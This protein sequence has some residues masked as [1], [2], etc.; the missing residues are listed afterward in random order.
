MICEATAMETDHGQCNPGCATVL[1][2][3]SCGWNYIFCEN[4]KVLTVPSRPSRAFSVSSVGAK[5]RLERS[6]ARPSC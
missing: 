1:R 5:E 4:M 3:L 2:K 6:I